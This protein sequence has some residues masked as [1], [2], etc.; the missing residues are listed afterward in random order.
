MVGLAGLDTGLRHALLQFGIPVLQKF[1]VINDCIVT[2]ND[3]GTGGGF[4]KMPIA[5]SCDVYFYDLAF[6]MGVDKMH[7]YLDRF[8]LGINAVADIAGSK[9]RIL[10]SREWKKEKNDCHGFQ[11]R[12]L[13]MG[14]GQGFMFSTPC[15]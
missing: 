8:G 10:P 11:G 9:R 12:P 15:S 4:T 14:I 13:N 5:E 2:G 3:G 7:E 1:G 6:K